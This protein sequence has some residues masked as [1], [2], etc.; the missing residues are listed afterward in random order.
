SAPYVIDLVRIDAGHTEIAA[1][2]ASGFETA[3]IG[4]RGIK[5]DRHTRREPMLD[6]KA[7]L[8]RRARFCMR[9]EIRHEQTGSLVGFG[10]LGQS[11][12]SHSESGF[13]GRGSRLRQRSGIGNMADDYIAC[14]FAVKAR[15]AAVSRECRVPAH[16]PSKMLVADGRGPC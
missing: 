16:V 9:C 7:D 1:P 3:C 10:H 4:K 12:E 13:N 6:T 2:R 11:V 14:G 8:G 5:A 15:C